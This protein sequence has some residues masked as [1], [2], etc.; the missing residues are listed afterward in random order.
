ADGAW[1]LVQRCVEATLW[2]HPLI[3]IARRRMAFIR[4]RAC[5]DFAVR[6]VGDF[7]LYGETLLDIAAGMTQRR[8]LGLGLALLRPISLAKRLAAIAHSAGSS[9]C[10]AAPGP[11]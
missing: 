2:F 8:A 9:R 4:E 11:R 1:Q 3:W 6:L 7:R 5:D 10:V